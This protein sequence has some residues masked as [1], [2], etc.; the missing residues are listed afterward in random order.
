[1]SSAGNV[2]R[3]AGACVALAF[4][5][6]GAA[7]SESGASASSV[8][9]GTFAWGNNSVGQLGNGTSQVI[10]QPQSVQLPTGVSAV[11]VAAGGRHAYAIGSDGLIYGWG[12]SGYGD[13]G[14]GPDAGTPCEGGYAP[15][16]SAPIVIPL[17]TGVTA[18]SIASG[19]QDGYAI[20]SDGKLYSWGYD[21]FGELGNGSISTTVNPTPAPVQLPAGVQ[22]VK[23]AAGNRSVLVVGSDGNL[24]SWGSNSNGQQ[25][26]GN[27]DDVA[28]PTQLSLAS[29]VSPIAIAA[30]ATN[31]YAI[32]SDGNVYAWGYNQDGELGDGTSGSPSLVPVVVGLPT[33]VDP[34][35]VSASDGAAFIETATG[36]VYAW[37]YND[38]GQLGDGT[39]SSTST[40]IAVSLPC[41][42]APGSVSPGNGGDGYAICTDG[43]L[44]GWGYNGDL[45]LG[46][47]TAGLNPL[48]PE[49]E[50][51]P[52]G[53]L[54]TSVVVGPSTTFAV[55]SD[56]QLYFWG[57]NSYGQSGSGIWVPYSGTPLQVSMPVGVT[58]TI[59]FGG[60]RD[61][62]AIA[63]NGN[64][65]A[66]GDNES[67][68]L[69]DGTASAFGPTPVKVS[70]P[71]GV[72]AV[73]GASDW[74]TT[75]ALGSDGNVY[76][77]GDDEHG[78]LGSG[79]AGSD[80]ICQPPGYG[81]GSPCAL[82]PQKVALPTGVTAVAVAA[83]QASGFAIGSDGNLYGWGWA[84]A[85][86]L[87]PTA[88]PNAVYD[89]PIVIP[90][91]AGV[92]PV[93]VSAGGEVAHVLG[94]DGNVYGWG[95]NEDGE[96][97]NGSSALTVPSPSKV[98]LPDGISAVSLTESGG[99]TYVTGSDGVLYTWGTNSYQELGPLGTNV[100]VPEPMVIPSGAL[101]TAVSAS[102]TNT[103][104]VGS[105][106][107]VYAWGWNA[108]GELGNGSVNGAGPTQVAL[109]SGFVPTA[110]GADGTDGGTGL[111]VSNVLTPQSITFT[112]TAPSAASSGGPTYQVSATGGGSGNGVTFSSATPNVCAVAGA[113]VTF[114]GD[115]M[116][117]VQ[118]DQAGNATYS[119]AK[120]AFQA[121]PVSLLSIGTAA[122]PPAQTG[123]AYSASL[124]A[125]GGAPPY[126]WS[127]TSGA[128][129]AGLH[130]DAAT[131]TVTGIPTAP[132]SQSVT[133][134]VGDPSGH[135][136]VAT[137]TMAVVT[138]PL[139]ITTTSVE[140]GKRRIAYSA[141]LSATNG[142][143]PYTWKLSSGQLPKGLKLNKLTGVITGTPSKTSVSST[144]TIEV[145]DAKVGK[146]KRQHTATATFTITIS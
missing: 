11:A 46:N 76:A 19:G 94:S 10:A 84:D 143:A 89:T 80:Q 56:G 139:T 104:V 112:S 119:A 53:V 16:S 23:V 115:G 17:P 2:L 42:I 72:T 117:I 36:G 136:A 144:F 100:N 91:P 138:G 30:D 122:L 21:G 77:W 99:D 9:S 57:D 81:S 22:P 47:N 87:G 96:I 24:Y 66:W 131:G 28:A 12:Y 83:A 120:H 35:S 128:L 62:Y 116:C 68:Q 73:A 54:P 107:N 102:G 92:A 55:G 74:N 1:M 20:G 88:N 145:L 14:P 15:C 39:T 29:G 109:P 5:G 65:Y 142:N 41:G 61:A 95:Y 127:I 130:L 49:P 110:I 71:P 44:Y 93:S 137:F 58:S 124:S 133:I 126:S 32:G 86:Q 70:L 103:Y 50:S 13:L 129:P 85:G 6:I 114:V 90:L 113:I 141:S 98:S 121:I 52:G 106:G 48:T 4:G 7:S 43:S 105:D 108:H 59:V 33:G 27:T 3:C 123:I 78:Q 51:L 97:G 67:G 60:A 79:Q 82:S 146:P 25:G 118:A 37:G 45:S 69:G 101:P 63:T 64:I 18:T 132:G 26:N 134:A 31:S 135:S 75:Y 40:P 140:G 38:I 125:S 34:V 111:V 8:P